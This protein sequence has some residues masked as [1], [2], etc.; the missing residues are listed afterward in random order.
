MYIEILEFKHRPNDGIA[1]RA[2][3][4]TKNQMLKK[5][6]EKFETNKEMKKMYVERKKKRE[7]EVQKQQ[8]E[9]GSG[10]RINGM[11]ENAIARIKKW[12]AN[13]RSE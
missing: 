7:T 12:T 6:M 5:K 13:K 8:E 10:S 4:F 2:E 1:I 9:V 3:R 11:K